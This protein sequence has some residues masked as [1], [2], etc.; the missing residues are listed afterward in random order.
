MK[1]ERNNQQDPTQS[2]DFAFQSTKR[3]SVM[4]H[5]PFFNDEN[6]QSQNPGSV[7]VERCTIS[8]LID[9]IATLTVHTP[10]RMSSPAATTKGSTTIPIN[11][12][13]S[14]EL[15]PRVLW[16]A[17]RG[18]RNRRSYSPTTWRT[19]KRQSPS[20]C[21]PAVVYVPNEF[22]DSI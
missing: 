14:T 9:R 3:G 21:I 10:K 1:T 12:V 15:M 6:K 7:S 16:S 4:V 13:S 11:T 20:G 5:K 8:D 22:D 17:V 19:T 2:F 18:K